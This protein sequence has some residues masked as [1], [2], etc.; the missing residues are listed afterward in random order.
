MGCKGTITRINM[1]QSL[2]CTQ[3]HAVTPFGIEIHP[4]AAPL[5]WIEG[6]NPIS[7]QIMT[8]MEGSYAGHGQPMNAEA[9]SINPATQRVQNVWY[10]WYL[11]SCHSLY[12]A[13]PFADRLC[14]WSWCFLQHLWKPIHHA[15]VMHQLQLPITEHSY[16]VLRQLQ[17]MASR[18]Y[19]DPSRRLLKLVRVSYRR[20]HT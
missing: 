11:T 16:L 10:S 9:E 12:R 17:A 18:L 14:K 19:H 20:T 3:T 8:R 1:S 2:Q 6:V 4:L 5:R 15:G 13:L 7:I